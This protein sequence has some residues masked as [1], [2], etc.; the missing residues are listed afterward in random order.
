MV[1]SLIGNNTHCQGSNH[2]TKGAC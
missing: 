2:S 1:S